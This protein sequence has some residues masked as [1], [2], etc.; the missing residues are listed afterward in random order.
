VLTI[1]DGSKVITGKFNGFD[2]EFRELPSLHKNSVLAPGNFKF[3]ENADFVRKLQSVSKM[4][5]ALRYSGAL[6]SDVHMLFVRS[7]GLFVRPVEDSKKPKL[8]LL[9][10]CA[11]LAL[12]VHALGGIAKSS[13]GLILD[14]EIYEYH[15]TTDVFLGNSDLVEMWLAE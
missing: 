9:Y 6:V 10:E 2:F 1:T 13:S 14:L 4:G 12:L 11:P 15:Q 3:I 7:G 5:L 8:R